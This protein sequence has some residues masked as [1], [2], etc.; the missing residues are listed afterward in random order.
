MRAAA[1]QVCLSSSTTTTTILIHTPSRQMDM[2]FFSS[3]PRIQVQ[4]TQNQSE[5]HQ[6]SF[7]QPIGFDDCKAATGA[8]AGPATAAGATA[9][10]AAALLIPALNLSLNLS[11]RL[12][13]PQLPQLP[14]LPQVPQAPSIPEAAS[15]TTATAK[16]PLPITTT[17]ITTTTRPRRSQHTPAPDA[18][19]YNELPVSQLPRLLSQDST[20]VV[21]IRPYAQFCSSR[22]PNAISLIVPSILLKRSSTDWN[23]ITAGITDPATLERFSRW[24][25]AA[26]IL[27]LDTDT[28]ILAESNNL[29]AFLRRFRIAGYSGNLSWVKGGMTA[30]YEDACSIVQLEHDSTSVVTTTTTTTTTIPPPLLHGCLCPRDLPIQAFQG[31]STTMLGQSK[32]TPSRETSSF[33]AANPFYDNIRQNVELA[34]GIGD[35][36]PLLVPDHIFSRRDDLPSQW[37]RDLLLQAE[38]ADHGA[39]MLA[40]QFYRI[41]LGE[42]RRLQGVMSHHSRQHDNT[43]PVDPP[44]TA[45]AQFPFSITAGIEMGTKNRSVVFSPSCFLLLP[46]HHPTL[47]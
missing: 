36:I 37:L 16:P 47:T 30:I 12:L 18:A 22:L 39:E 46:T 28:T 2:D 32:S 11:Q 41:E 14:Q 45:P 27:I 9:A 3:K 29:L 13:E 38:T 25:S 4:E 20:L 21:D 1:P 26:T 8:A 7:A 24:R 23:R 19:E 43:R 33:T 5:N 42:Q 35:K 31:T 15:T 34:N 17:T 44:S 40:L 10:G 6:S